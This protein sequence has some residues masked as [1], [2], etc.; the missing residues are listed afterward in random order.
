MQF[1]E[2]EEYCKI[3]TPVDDSHITYDD[4]NDKYLYDDGDIS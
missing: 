2:E 4:E 1:F 3:Y